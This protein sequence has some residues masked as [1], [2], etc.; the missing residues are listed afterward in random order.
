MA[1]QHEKR[2]PTRCALYVRV[3]TGPQV[4]GNSLGTQRRQLL[5][6]AEARGYSVVD[7]YVDAGLS[8][9]NMERPELQHLLADARARKLDVV[10]V[11]RVDRISRSLP[12]LVGLVGVLREHGVEFAAVDQDFDTTDPVGLLTLHMLGS[13]AQFEREL[14]VD[15]VKEAHLS[16]LK[17]RDWSCG[18]VPYGYRKV[19]GRLV[20]K[21]EQAEVVR[22]IFR[23]YLEMRS[24]RGVARRLSEEAVPAPRGKKWWGETVKGILTNPV[25]AGCNV[26]GRHRKGDTRVRPRDEW[27]VV[28]GMRGGLVRPGVFREA[29]QRIGAEAARHAIPGRGAAGEARRH[30][31]ST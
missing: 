23:L 26:Y 11:A 8:G 4:E 25:Y 28:P 10:L 27:T 19:D 30:A 29:Q 1:R 14:M 16:R 31:V 18:P 22:R 5:R 6:Y 15:R 20:E 9:K 12:D 13:F 3:S 7:F 17:T 21:P 24:F 2:G